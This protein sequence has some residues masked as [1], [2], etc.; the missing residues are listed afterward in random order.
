M[1]GRLRRFV[2]DSAAGDG[3]DA[4]CD[5]VSGACDKRASL[6][7]GKHFECAEPTCDICY[8]QLVLLILAS[9]SSASPPPPPAAAA[10]GDHARVSLAACM[11]TSHAIMTDY[12]CIN[13]VCIHNC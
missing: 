11:S 2:V 10:A 6:Y 3:G 13:D 9:S 5:E 12:N 4:G 8:R 7:T 1:L